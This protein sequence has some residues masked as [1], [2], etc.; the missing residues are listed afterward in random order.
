MRGRAVDDSGGVGEVEYVE[1]VGKPISFSR[2]DG[3]KGLEKVGDD[4]QGS[5]LEECP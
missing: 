2:K 1:A 4:S 3:E 5:E